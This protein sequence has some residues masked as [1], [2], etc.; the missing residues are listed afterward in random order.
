MQ[1]Q[2]SDLQLKN[3]EHDELKVSFQKVQEELA[4]SRKKLSFTQKATEQRLLDSI[5]NPDGFHTD[6]L[7]IGVYSATLDEDEFLFDENSS[8]NLEK[9]DQSN[10]G[11]SRKELFLKS[12]E[13]KLD[14]KN[15]EQKERLTVIKNQILEKVKTTQLSRTRNRSSSSRKRELSPDGSALTEQ[16][17]PVR[18]KTTGIPQKL[19]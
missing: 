6:P 18:R 16:N 3:K 14:P 12:I 8:S 13:Q 1:K 7:L 2:V 5:E 17:S 4:T 19:V 15:S 11:R 10:T 9:N